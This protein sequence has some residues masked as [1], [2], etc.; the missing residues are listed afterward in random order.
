MDHASSRRWLWLAAVVTMPVPFYLGD[1]EWAPVLRLAFLSS[2]FVAVAIAEGG[3][4]ILALG[5]LGVVQTLVYG[6]LFYVV[7]DFGARL[8]GLIESAPI[9]VAAVG[10]V[11]FL[12]GVSSLLPIYDTPLSSS[13]PRSSIGQIFE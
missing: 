8:L 12:L 3:N 13:R 6:G 4:T 10:T 5:G 9:R 1:P 7:A 11:V 2:L